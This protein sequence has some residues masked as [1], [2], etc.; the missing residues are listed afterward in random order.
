MNNN[1]KAFGLHLIIVIMSLFFVIIFVATG[2]AIGKYSTNIFSRLIIGITFVS[3]YFFAGT[4][5]DTTQNKKYD[6][7]VGCF[8]GII[9]IAIWFYTFS[10]TGSNLFEVSEELSEHWI[11]MN[12]YQSPFIMVNFLLGLSNIPVLSL[13]INFI[14]SFLMGCG[15][16]IVGQLSRQKNI[17]F[18]MN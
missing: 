14:P 13:I 1:F 7:L 8:I 16:N 5:L 11:L 3:V 17:N 18:L 12:I 2:P 4:L 10:I 9:G 6:F 15:V